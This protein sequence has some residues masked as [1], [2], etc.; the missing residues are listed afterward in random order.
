M[1]LYR[2]GVILLYLLEDIG[3]GSPQSTCKS[4]RFEPEDELTLITIKLTLLS[5]VIKTYRLS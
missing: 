3:E 1:V 4:E 5:A 2:S